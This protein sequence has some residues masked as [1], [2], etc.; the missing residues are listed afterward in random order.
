MTRHVFTREESAR[1]GLTTNEKKLA[2]QRENGRRSG[3][4][5]G[6]MRTEA[7]TAARRRERPGQSPLTL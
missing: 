2:V 1:G 3:L 4:L 7:Q 6:G 5:T